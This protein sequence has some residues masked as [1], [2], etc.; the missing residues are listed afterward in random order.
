MKHPNIIRLSILT[1]TG[2]IIGFIT[3]LVLTILFSL[4]TKDLI[5]PKIYFVASI[6]T[7]ATIGVS[8][9]YLYLKVIRK[10][11]YTC[12]YR[13]L[14][15]FLLYDAAILVGGLIGKGIL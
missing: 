11:P 1:V 14:T 15:S 7:L 13:Y 2:I 3:E 6:L 12:N 8:L 5:D 4:V 10:F 9:L